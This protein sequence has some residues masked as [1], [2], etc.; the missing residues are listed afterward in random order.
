M[1]GV[2]EFYTI[3]RVAVITAEL[4]LSKSNTR[5]DGRKVCPK[6]TTIAVTL[7]STGWRSAQGDSGKA[8]THS[9]E[10]MRS[11]PHPQVKSKC[12]LTT[13]VVL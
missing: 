7:A 4:T 2:E 6:P 12:L 5:E 3:R 11:L 8:Q 1:Q 9:G 10:R 13:T